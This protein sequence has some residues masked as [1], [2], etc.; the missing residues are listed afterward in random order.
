MHRVHLRAPRLWLVSPHRA[1]GKPPQPRRPRQHR[2]G[3]S[4]L[5]A[6]VRLPFCF[7]SEARNPRGACRPAR[8]LHPQGT[9]SRRR[10]GRVRGSAASLP[11]GENRVAQDF[12]RSRGHVLPSPSQVPRGL[13]N[14]L[15]GGKYLFA[16]SHFKNL[17]SNENIGL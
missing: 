3:R 10:N 5:P 9:K 1:H 12:P 2:D 14:N 8:H 17:C 6:A 13:R 15:S 16:Q 11:Q 4:R 7:S